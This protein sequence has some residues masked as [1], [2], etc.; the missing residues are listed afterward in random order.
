MNAQEASLELDENQEE[1]LNARGKS[2]PWPN[3]T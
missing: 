2:H 3:V 1:K